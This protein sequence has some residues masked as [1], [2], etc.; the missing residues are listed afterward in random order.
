MLQAT[1]APSKQIVLQE[2]ESPSSDFLQ[3]LFLLLTTI[4]QKP[5]RWPSQYCI[6]CNIEYIL[7]YCITD[8]SIRQ[9][10]GYKRKQ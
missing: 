2:L 4:T 10:E 6:Y 1:S 8:S 3:S 7:Q 9:S 5:I